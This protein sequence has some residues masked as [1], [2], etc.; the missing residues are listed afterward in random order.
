V[1]G[2][3]ILGVWCAPAVA[4]PRDVIPDAGVDIG[5]DPA[6]AIREIDLAAATG[7]PWVRIAVPWSDLE[8]SPQADPG[9]TEAW[10]H[11][12]EQLGHAHARGL[13]TLLVLADAPGWASGRPGAANDPPTP[14]NL[15]R[16][17]AFLRTLAGRLGGLIDAYS[18]WNEPNTTYAWQ[19]VSATAYARLQAVAYDAIKEA[20]PT[21]LVLSAAIA[22]GRNSAYTFL[23]QAYVAG[24]RGHVDVLAWN[25]YPSGPPEGGPR[26]AKREPPS[27]SSLAG[28]LY[29][30]RLLDRL[31][32]GRPIWIT[33]LGWS[34]CRPCTDFANNSASDAVQGDYLVRAF[35]YRRRY[36]AGSTERIFWYQMRDGPDPQAWNQNSGLVRNDF[37]PKPALL[38]LGT[39]AVGPRGLGARTARI[40]PPPLPA[41]AARAAAGPPAAGSGARRVDLGPAQVA[42]RAGTIDLTVEV[43][44]QGAGTRVAVEAYGDGAWRRVATVSV[45][46]SSTIAAVI[47]DH[48][49]LALVLRAP[50]GGSGPA[51]TRLVRL[52]SAPAAA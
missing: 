4:A 29:L 6:G 47:P 39:L 3:A 52:P 49:Y 7:I 31:D 34:T 12:A 2:L 45:P 1:A 20:D 40:P 15:P 9:A 23:R 25:A 27:S 8:P 41:A 18:P 30:R 22:G 17:A 32:P 48:G 28:Q 36:L 38:A 50:T 10:A 51:A 44:L 16:Y 35:V 13:R 46:R 11:L 21:A 42:V 26:E 14:P 33:E 5:S 24:L 19:P 37:A 43:R